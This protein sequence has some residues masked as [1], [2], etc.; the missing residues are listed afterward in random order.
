MD[1]IINIKEGAS[2]TV[3]NE[4]DE[5]DLFA[6]SWDDL[7]TWQG[8]DD[9]NFR[10]RTSRRDTEVQKSY[11]D[12][13]KQQPE[14][15]GAGSK[16]INPGVQ[17][18]NGYGA[19]DVI[20]PPYN[21]YQLASFY[22]DNY[23]NHAAI[24]AKVMNVVGEGYKF[25]ISFDARRAKAKLSSDDDLSAL[26]QEVNDVAS[27]MWGVFDRL[28][29]SADFI[30]TMTDVLVDLESTGN[31]YLEVGRTTTGKIGYLG[32][33]PATTIRVRRMRDGFVQAISNRVVY[34]RNFG[35][36][37]P[38][39]IGGDPFPNEIIHLKKYSP[40]NTYYGVPDVASV[41]PTMVGDRLASEYNADY[42][43]NK[44]VPRYIF[45]I[46]GAKLSDD[47]ERK[48]FNFLQSDLKGQHHRT[49]VVPLPADGPDGTKVEVKMEPVEAKIQD[50]SFKE[51]RRDNRAAVLLAHRVPPSKLGASD[52]ESV[53]AAIAQDRTFR[54]QVC[55]P[56]QRYLE[57]ALSPIV[58][59]HT[60]LVDLKFVR[61]NI[62]DEVQEASIHKTYLDSGVITPNEVRRKINLP[63]IDGLD[64]VR[65]VEK[66]QS[67]IDRESERE[68]ESSDSPNSATGRNPKGS[69]SKRDKGVV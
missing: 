59:E 58:R 53:A 14:G 40:L 45:W 3:I 2:V 11:S 7:K 44:A 68:T 61:A 4:Y 23:A 6:K 56:I 69:G 64:Q 41:I 25:E 60:D 13:S 1:Q 42:F 12:L 33:I 10:R 31:G 19:F 27:D 50:A 30:T 57:K 21:L 22:D 15:A 16:Q 62:I 46:K 8:L 36:T 39:P 26:D 18:I 66:P 34:F 43:D 32:H 17:F 47:S 67:I 28:N 55:Q 52:A 35:G 9:V 20:T 49:L 37:N 29:T 65:P 63:A 24:T 5:F 51:Y 38:D 54:D 48:L